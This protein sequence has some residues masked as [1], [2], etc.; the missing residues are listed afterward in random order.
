[1]IKIV[2][3]HYLQILTN[4]NEKYFKMSGFSRYFIASDWKSIS[5]GKWFEFEI[6]AVQDNWVQESEV[7]QTVTEGNIPL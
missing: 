1:M 5:K 2:E 3:P 6:A 7:V 4:E